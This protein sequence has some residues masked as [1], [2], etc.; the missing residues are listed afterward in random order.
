MLLFHL[1]K[2]TYKVFLAWF[3]TYKNVD[4]FVKFYRPSPTFMSVETIISSHCIFN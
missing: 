2:K 1:E 4:Q 3:P